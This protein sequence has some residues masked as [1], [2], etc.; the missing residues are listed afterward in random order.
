LKCRK[1]KR[2]L[3]LEAEACPWCRTRVEEV[4]ELVIIPVILPVQGDKSDQAKELTPSPTKEEVIEPKPAE[5]MGVLA[6][7]AWYFK[8]EYLVICP[9][10]SRFGIKSAIK[11]NEIYCPICGTLCAIDLVL[12]A[13]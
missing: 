10:H 6:K 11:L 13:S 9:K 2:L 12:R 8:F 3:P 1:C 4:Q 7:S 5:P